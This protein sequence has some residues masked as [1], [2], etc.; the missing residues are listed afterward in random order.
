M[1]TSH[2]EARAIAAGYDSSPVLTELSLTLP[3][4]ALTGLIG[5]NGAGKTT[6][7]LALSGQFRPARGSIRFGGRDIYQENLAYKYRIG[8]VHEQP[9]F[10][11]WLTAGEFLA[12]VAHVKKV[13]PG[14]IADESAR[15]LQR[16]GLEGE[17]D[18]RTSDLSLGMKKKLAIAAA[19]MGEPAVLFL[20]EALNGVDI[21]SAYGI[22]QM[23]R[24]YVQGGGLVILSTHVLEVI[25]KICDRYVVLQSGRILADVEAAA[26]RSG[27]GA[28]SL[29]E[30]IIALLHQHGH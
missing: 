23:L 14:R 22:K 13:D 19:F 2:L 18:K 29:E 30:H 3:A 27:A 5:P 26:W 28:A 8:Y 11:P 4:G 7:M 24:E 16:V 12:F 1:T 21:E 9:F 17:Q 20:D 25:E 10:Y 15:L 6:L